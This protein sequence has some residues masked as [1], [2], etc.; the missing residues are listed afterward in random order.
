MNSSS[1]SSSPAKAM[2]ESQVHSADEYSLLV[3]V[4][5]LV[6]LLVP[7]KQTVPQ[8]PDGPSCSSITPLAEHT[9]AVSV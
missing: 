6:C 1:G 7:L 4:S 2:D 9:V 5:S 3:P 8:D